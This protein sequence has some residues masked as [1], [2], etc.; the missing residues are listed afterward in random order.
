MQI[1]TLNTYSY[2]HKQ[3]TLTDIHSQC[4]YQLLLLTDTETHV[5]PHTEMGKFIHMDHPP[6]HTCRH[7]YKCTQTHTYRKT[8]SQRPHM[9][10]H[11]HT[12]TPPQHPLTYTH[13]HTSTYPP[14]HTHRDPLAHMHRLT[15]TGTRTHTCRPIHTQAC[16]HTCCRGTRG[17]LCGCSCDL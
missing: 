9:G 11:I 14:S 16:S 10:R 2:T 7:T 3:A 17:Q 6:T 15:Q 1:S 8:L 5:F 4:I 13:K 12:D